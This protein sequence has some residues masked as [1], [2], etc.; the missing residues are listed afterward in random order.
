MNLQEMKML[1]EVQSEAYKTSLQVFVDQFN[2]NIAACQDT[3]AELRKSLE[4]SQAQMDEMKGQIKLVQA[5]KRSDANTIDALRKEVAE[6][7]DKLES[8]A[9]R[10]NELND[11]QRR[12]NLRIDGLPE[13]DAETPEQTAVSV[14]SLLQEKLELPS[15]SMESAHR[16]GQRQEN[17]PRPVVVKFKRQVD[18]DAALRHGKKL[19]GT[20]IYLN[21]DLCPASQKMKADQLPALRAARAQGKIAYFVNTKL[22]IKEKTNHQRPGSENAAQPNHSSTMDK[23]HQPSQ[24][25]RLAETDRRITRQTASASQQQV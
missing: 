8:F 12:N 23:Q 13:V 7:W 2:A 24:H 21:E 19:K 17:R 5:E 20:K 14:T 18:R 16:M 15:L 10:C 3:V 9:I 4:F 22:V 25:P 6:T 11:L 1:M